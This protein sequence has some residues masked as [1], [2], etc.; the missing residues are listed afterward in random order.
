[1]KNEDYKPELSL[2]QKLFKELESPVIDVSAM[3]DMQFIR[4]N[5]GN[6]RRVDMVA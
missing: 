1:M 6:F 3:K 2:L 4:N 5:V